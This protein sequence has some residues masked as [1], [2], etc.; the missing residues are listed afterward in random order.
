MLLTP[1]VV[2]VCVLTNSMQTGV[3]VGHYA[4]HVVQAPAKWVFL[5]SEK[6]KIIQLCINKGLLSV[7]VL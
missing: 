4:Q 1:A 2:A 3:S 5:Q 6:V 7:C